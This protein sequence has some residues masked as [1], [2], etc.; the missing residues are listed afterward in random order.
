MFRVFIWC[1]LFVV[2]LALAPYLLS[3]NGQVVIYFADYSYSLS[4]L[5]FLVFFLLAFGAFEIIASLVRYLYKITFGWFAN[6]RE[7][8]QAKAD[9]L[10]EKGLRQALVGDY[11]QAQKT[12]A[13]SA[14]KANLPFY[15]LSQTFDL[16]IRNRN[17]R[18]AKELL[19]R[20][21][22]VNQET[23]S[24][25]KLL[26]VSKLKY[27]VATEQ[28]QKA[29]SFLDKIRLEN[30]S[31]EVELIA[32]K[33]YLNTNQYAMLEDLVPNLVKKEYI[34]AEKGQEDLAWAYQGLMQRQLKQ[35]ENKANELVTWFD[36]QNR[37]HRSNLVFRNQM[38]KSLLQLNAYYDAIDVAS[39]TLR[40][41][42]LKDIAQSDYF[43][44]ISQ[45]PHDTLDFKLCRALEKVLP[46]FEQEQQFTI[47]AILAELYYRQSKFDKAQVWV[48]KLL[49]SQTPTPENILLAQVVY[50]KNNDSEKLLGLTKLIDRQYDLSENTAN[51]E[52]K[53]QD[54]KQGQDQTAS[55]AAGDKANKADKA[56][57]VVEKKEA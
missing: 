56:N 50:R 1:L 42:S 39:E 53:D 19:L 7:R 12:L 27:Y 44:L 6:R 16:A 37:S 22:E 52:A 38:L 18:L 51:T 13:K 10:V 17:P 43:S 11:R 4:L 47:M 41:C 9:R 46:K 57:T 26:D 8:R 40:R 5:T 29:S 48:E 20:M 24:D 36:A 25:K 28:W 30:P 33:V 35:N 23:N 34:S 3:H 31:E 55:V 15:N 14:T 45:I 21:I 2:L 32:R 54:Q 49:T